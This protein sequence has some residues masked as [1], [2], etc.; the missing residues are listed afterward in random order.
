M[1]PIAGSSL[2]VAVHYVGL[3]AVVVLKV[4]GTK[5]RRIKPRRAAAC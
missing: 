5:T 3:V 1:C 2:Q 4:I